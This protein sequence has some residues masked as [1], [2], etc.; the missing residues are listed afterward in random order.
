MQ[1]Y[2]EHRNWQHSQAQVEARK[3]SLKAT[4]PGSRFSRRP[5]GE[6]C[7]QRQHRLARRLLGMGTQLLSTGRRS[8]G[9]AREEM[10]VS[11]GVEE[12]SRVRCGAVDRRFL[13]FLSVL[14]LPFPN[15]FPTSQCAFGRRS[16]LAAVRASKS[17]HGRGGRAETVKR[18]LQHKDRAVTAKHKRRRRKKSRDAN[19]EWKMAHRTKIR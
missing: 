6:I 19:A 14:F 7:A 10:S 17:R 18:W 13:P 5:A 2:A 16:E 3:A 15:R 8:M 1:S 9:S 11:M 4:G 12:L